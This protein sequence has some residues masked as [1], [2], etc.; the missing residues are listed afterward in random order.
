MPASTP[1]STPILNLFCKAV[2]PDI[3]AN[4]SK[5]TIERKKHLQVINMMMKSVSAITITKH[6]LP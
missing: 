2:I 6:I 1:A 5:K 4:E 3:E